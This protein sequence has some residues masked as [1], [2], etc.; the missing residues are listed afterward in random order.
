[1]SD[2]EDAVER[3]ARLE[4]R[5]RRER[6]ARDEAERLLE[7]KSLELYQANVKLSR[8]AAEL[9]RRVEERTRELD[10]A[11]ER[12]IEI[13]N[14]DQLTGLANRGSFAGEGEILR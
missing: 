9:E 6:A 12:A 8:F 1:M 11:R 5:A 4:R 2:T 13:A 3:L 10:D 7:A 14:Q